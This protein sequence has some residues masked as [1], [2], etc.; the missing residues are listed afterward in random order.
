MIKRFPSPYKYVNWILIALLI[1]A[2]VVGFLL[3]QA[4]QQIPD[5]I[6]SNVV[7]KQNDYGFFLG[8]MDNYFTHNHTMTY[9]GQKAFAGRMPGYGMPYLLLRFIMSQQAALVTLILLQVLLSAISVY[10]LARIALMLLK[11]EKF[12][13]VTFFVFGI[14]AYTSLYD[15]FT[16]AESFAV[17][18]V[19]FTFF[20]VCRYIDFRMKKDLLFAGFFLAWSIFLRPFLGLI[21]VIVPLLLLLW[22][23]KQTNFKKAFISVV[24]LCI[25]FGVFESAWIVRNYISLKKFVPL[26]TELDEAYGKFGAYRSSSIA[27]RKLITAWGGVSGEFYDGSEAWWFHYATGD[28]VNSYQFKPHVFNS[29]LTKDSL[30]YL[31]KVF[32]ESGDLT[33][34]YPYLDSVNK[35]A[36]SIATRYRK[37]YTSNNIVRVYLLNPFIR[38]KQMVLSNPSLLM[39]FPKFNKMNIFQKTI[40]LVYVGLYFVVVFMGFFGIIA[41]LF[42]G[43]RDVRWNMLLLFPPAVILAIIFNPLSII[44]NRY[45][46]TAYPVFILFGVYLHSVFPKKQETS[47]DS[48]S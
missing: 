16:L 43:K 44:E 20:Y 47:N 46:L 6:V 26:E 30:I 5:R 31:K 15:I 39:P 1:K 48:S 25:P 4:H 9:D 18:S 32:N 22:E 10:V 23:T 41:Y 13:Y 11:K 29:G 14:S 33:K 19:I 45:F 27:V 12:F 7:V 24:I 28:Q 2:I 34:P 35:I 38:I 17:S 21:I 42:R 40:K 3:Y 37:Q 8:V 36:E